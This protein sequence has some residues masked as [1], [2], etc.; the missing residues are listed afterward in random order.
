MASSLMQR[1]KNMILV[2][3]ASAAMIF[4]TLIVT[5]LILSND[6]TPI[7]PL[8]KSK[9][10]LIAVTPIDLSSKIAIE[11][12]KEGTTNWTLDSGVNTRFIQGYA[13]SVSAIPGES[14]GI[15]VSS[16]APLSYHFDVYRIGWYGG[17]GGHLYYTS[18]AITSQA[19][20]YW[21]PATGLICSKCK[22]D[23]TTREVDANWDKSADLTIG[24]NW[25]SGAYLIKLVGSNHSQSYIPLVIRDSL[26]HSSLLVSL[27][28]NTYA[29]YNLWGGYSL[30][31]EYQPSGIPLF[32]KRA[33]H[34]SFNRPYERSAGASDFLSW[35]IQNIRFLERSGYDVSYSTNVDMDAHPQEL[36][37]H[38]IFVSVGHDEYW[39]KAMR[40]GAEAARDK[41]ISLAFFGSNDCYW[42][43]RI[44]SD[45]TDTPGRVVVSYKVQTKVDP[46]LPNGPTEQL[47]NDPVYP[48]HPELV[49]AQ[50]RD[51]VV[52]RPENALM[53]LMYRSY[54][55]TIY[56]YTPD[57]IV[58]SGSTDAL[59]IN[60]DLKPGQHIKG[61][62]LGY[63]YD[64][65]DNNGFTPK[66]LV[67]LAQSP[68][69]LN[70]G[71]SQ[72][73]T[74]ANTSYY[75]APSGAMVFD[76]GSIWW[77]WGLDDF[78][79]PG[80]YQSNF[81]KGNNSIIKLTNNIFEAMLI[82]SPAGGNATPVPTITSSP[83][84]KR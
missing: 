46:N 38:R 1:R 30:Y 17:T 4:I 14:V 35:D 28:V 49:T 18:P 29:A 3:I 79:A 74:N 63:E 72:E 21:T 39:T 55:N 73:T 44:E 32:S 64:S 48:A 27:P 42:Q 24:T 59:L 58:S 31:G 60:T 70:Y 83:T 53:G 75:Y 47:K 22:V 45:A 7:A 6:D 50:W 13:N 2:F 82:A 5:L 84:P 8:I 36:L 34:V 43:A 37:Q 56:G 9:T 33:S 71:L 12:Q 66:N 61:G 16:E 80:A 81:F 57:W 26:S 23:P 40:D 25:P 20:G 54:F 78:S 68:V 77:G 19:Q 67:I 51:P 65:Y 11:N 69:R 52:N 15:Y 62:F 10:T 41:G 76:A